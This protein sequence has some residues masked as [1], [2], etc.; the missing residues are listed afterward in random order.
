VSITGNVINLIHAMAINDN[1]KEGLKTETIAGTILYDSSWIAG[2]DY[3]LTIENEENDEM[4][5]NGVE[6]DENTYLDDINLNVLADIL[7]DNA[8]KTLV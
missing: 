2:V 4:T 1:M 5:K 6:N 3:D 7:R 8:S